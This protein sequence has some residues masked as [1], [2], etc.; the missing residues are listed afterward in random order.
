MR[1]RLCQFKE[2]PFPDIYVSKFFLFESIVFESLYSYIYTGIHGIHEILF[3][4][5]MICLFVY[6]TCRYPPSVFINKGSS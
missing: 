3:S 1:L 4:L 5:L 2:D 6:V